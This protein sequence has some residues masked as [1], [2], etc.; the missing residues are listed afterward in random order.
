ML[1]SRGWL[2][3]ARALFFEPALESSLKVSTKNKF[4]DGFRLLRLEMRP[5]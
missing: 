1:F 3:L 4:V 2:M 5:D